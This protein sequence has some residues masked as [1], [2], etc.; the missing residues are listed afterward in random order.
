MTITFAVS[1]KKEDKINIKNFKQKFRFN[2]FL[3]RDDFEEIKKEKKVI[4]SSP[5]EENRCYNVGVNSFILSGFLAYS[6]H[7]HLVLRP[8]DIWFAVINQ[9]SLYLNA[10]S[11]Q[12]GPKILGEGYDGKKK[13]LEIESNKGSLFDGPYEEMTIAMTE[14]ISSKIKDKSIRSWIIPDFTTTTFTDK[15]V[16]SIAL[17]A[18]MQS[19]FSYKYSFRCGLPK[20]TLLG[21]VDDWKDVKK[22]VEKLREFDAGDGLILEWLNMLHPVMDQLIETASG[23][24]NNDLKDWWNQIG[25]RVIG[26]SGPSYLSGWICVFAVF[27]KDGKW[28]NTKEK[29]SFHKKIIS[30]WGFVDLD[31]IPTGYLSVPLTISDDREGKSYKSEMYAGHMC[32]NVHPDKTTISP[33]LDWC[34][35]LNEE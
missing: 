32:V 10:N 2:N 23:N 33:Q 11:S 34:I 35:L 7:H 26:G 29:T 1:D 8:D 3:V 16:N 28:I 19:Y 6:G 15:I 5:I 4:K 18:T 25:N 22:R 31:K 17:M 20:V 27:D 30:E 12:L 24:I 9:F 13:E 14:L 21:T